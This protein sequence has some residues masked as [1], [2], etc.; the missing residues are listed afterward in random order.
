LYSF[1]PIYYHSTAKLHRKT[2]KEREHDE[3]LAKLVSKAQREA[4]RKAHA[5]EEQKKAVARA[6]KKILMGK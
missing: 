6:Q 4:A 1:P 3:Y 5:E 2:Q